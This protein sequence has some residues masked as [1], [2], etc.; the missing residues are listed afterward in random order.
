MIVTGKI[1]RLKVVRESDAGYHLADEDGKE[2]LLPASHAK[3][4]FRKGDKVEVFIYTDSDSRQIASLQ[5]PVVQLNNY[6]L[7]RVSDVTEHGAFM[8]W[9]PE[10]DLFIPFSEQKFPMEKEKFYVV[11]VY[12]DEVSKRIVG[13][14]RLDK[15]LSNEGHTLEGGQEV[16]VFIYEE[17]PLGF[18]CIINGKHT[19]LIY[20]NDVFQDLF[21]GDELIAYVKTIREDGLIDISLQKSGFKNVL[22][23]TDTILEYLQT[24]NGFCNLHDKSAPEDIADKFSMSKAT[25]K[26]AIGI[27]Y[28]QRK[29]LIKPDGVYLVK[30]EPEGATDSVVATL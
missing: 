4:K 15:F 26:K 10:K 29:V 25:Y 23:A 22:S 30:D 6:A 12:L 2:V 14:S 5:R 9:G 21:I 3:E 20:H 8:K 24:R 18:S 28:R 7:L 1:N 19:G 13:S 27:L 17:S 16:E 11:Y